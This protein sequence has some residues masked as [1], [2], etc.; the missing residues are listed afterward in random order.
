M[1][2]IT[3]LVA[4]L[5]MLGSTATA[6]KTGLAQTS[7]VSGKLDKT[8]NDTLRAYQ[9]RLDSSLIKVS[10]T[11]LNSTAFYT[12]DSLNLRKILGALKGTA[13]DTVIFVIK[14]GTDRSATGTT[15]VTDT[16]WSLTTG[17]SLTTFAAGS[18]SP[19]SWVW[20]TAT[21]I[22]GTPKGAFLYIRAR[23]R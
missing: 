8:D 21:K 7:A 4:L 13:G 9:V 2:T 18:V 6:Q 5:L 14:S 15:V 12:E 3:I 20:L 11:G 22:V 16:V 19:A 10:G 17:T 1:K 23:R